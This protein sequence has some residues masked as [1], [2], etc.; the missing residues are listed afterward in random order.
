MLNAL[1]GSATV[2]VY[3]ND[4]LKLSNLP[5]TLCCLRPV[6]HVTSSKLKKWLCGCALRFA[7]PLLLVTKNKK[8][9]QLVVQH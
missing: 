9:I 6:L 3:K 4:L 8:E 5:A 2:G 7:E 1:V